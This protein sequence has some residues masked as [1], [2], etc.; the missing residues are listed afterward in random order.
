MTPAP[1]L[2]SQ[3]CYPVSSEESRVRQPEAMSASSRHP[4][5]PLPLI[6]GSC[7]DKTPVS[8][9]FAYATLPDQGRHRS[10]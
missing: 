4:P 6:T 5:L 1:T 8:T 2:A 3:L 10:R 7:P 9:S